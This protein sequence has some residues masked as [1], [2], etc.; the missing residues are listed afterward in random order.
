M[1]SIDGPSVKIKINDQII[2]QVSHFIYL[3]NYIH[4]VTN[5]DIRVDT[6]LNKFQIICRTSTRISKNMVRRETRSKALQSYDC[7][8][9]VNY[10]DN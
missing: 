1:W 2:E 3:M 8:C 9:T 10:D 7:P 5:Y 6:K 4:Y